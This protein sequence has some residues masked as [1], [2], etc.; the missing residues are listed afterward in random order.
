M[1]TTERQK[2]EWL[3]ALAK[4]KPTRG[5]SHDIAI[6]LVCRYL[7]SW[8]G[9][10]ALATELG[11]SQRGCIHAWKS[12][13]Q[14][15]WLERVRDGG[16]RHASRYRLRRPLLRRQLHPSAVE[17]V[18]AAPSDAEPMPT[19]AAAGSQCSRLQL[20]QAENPDDD[21]AWWETVG[22]WEE[23]DALERQREWEQRGVWEELDA[24]EL[25]ALQRQQQ[26]WEH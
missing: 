23:L 10:N 15:G 2:L 5:A 6:L 8:P 7:D 3:E 9:V 22:V 14:Y 16:G 13:V 1:T 26:A 24:L 19:A 21:Q 18:Q 11:I 20:S 12:L 4:H 25:D 17:Q